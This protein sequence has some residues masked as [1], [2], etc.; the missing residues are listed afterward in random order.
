MTS[1]RGLVGSVL[2]LVIAKRPASQPCNG[3]WKTYLYYFRTVHRVHSSVFQWT[4]SHT[5]WP[6][7]HHR[8]SSPLLES[9]CI[10]IGCNKRLITAHQIDNN[11]TLSFPLCASLSLGHFVVPLWLTASATNWCSIA[12]IALWYDAIVRPG[13]SLLASEHTASISL[14]FSCTQIYYFSFIQF[15]MF[16]HLFNSIVCISA[17]SVLLLPGFEAAAC[18]WNHCI[19]NANKSIS[20]LIGNRMAWQKPN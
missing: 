5:N 20:F 10:C 2:H 15:L 13:C 9:L 16:I 4:L 1:D 17:P 6:F 19:E 7:F 14:S 12:I 11:K 18:E 8:F 3:R